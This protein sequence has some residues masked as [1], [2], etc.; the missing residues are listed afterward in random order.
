MQPNSQRKH[1]IRQTW[2]K[3][4]DKDGNSTYL[5]SVYARSEFIISLPAILSF[6]IYIAISVTLNWGFY[7]RLTFF[8]ILYALVDNSYSKHHYKQLTKHTQ[9]FLT[10]LNQK[11]PPS[12]SLIQ[13]VWVEIDGFALRFVKKGNAL[14]LIFALVGGLA[15]GWTLHNWIYTLVSWVGLLLASAIVTPL[16]FFYAD[17]FFYPVKRFCF[18]YNLQ[19]DKDISGFAHLQNSKEDCK[20]SA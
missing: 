12:P 13:D 17:W 9:L 4:A 20:L 2:L 5:S 6:F 7:G 16:W 14:I 10:K 1:D 8:F 11:E 19:I 18:E 15:A 3:K